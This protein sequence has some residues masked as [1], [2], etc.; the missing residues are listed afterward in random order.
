VQVDPGIDPWLI[1]GIVMGCVAAVLVAG[2]FLAS[3][4]L[5]PD[6][7]NRERQSGGDH[8]EHRRRD[9]IRYYLESIDE[10]YEEE[11]E[12]AGH[13]VAF[14]LPERDV[15]I[16][17][18]ARA[19]LEL[20][21]T[22]YESVL[23]EHEMPGAQLGDRLPFETPTVG[24]EGADGRRERHGEPTAD[25]TRREWTGRG[26]TTGA[27]HRRRGRSGVHEGS[28]QQLTREEV[29]ASFAAL[30]LPITASER[31]VKEAYRRRVKDLHP[32]HGGDEEAFQD[33]QEAYDAAREHAD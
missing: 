7:R 24:D 26:R 2:V 17:F 31:E 23:C 3:Q 15:A 13:S 5:F 4:R 19:F 9:E 1:T 8:G 6:P 32:D 16:T 25:G 30:G 12:V 20:R 22:E 14:F 29:A 18:D 11:T 21:D 10:P 28:G 33:L 27:G